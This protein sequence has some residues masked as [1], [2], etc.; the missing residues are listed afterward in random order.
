MATRPKRRKK[1]DSSPAVPA[2]SAPAT[3]NQSIEDL[4]RGY[5]SSI[6]PTI[7][8]TCRQVITEKMYTMQ[9]SA[10]SN[11]PPSAP[12]SQAPQQMA[13]TLTTPTLLQEITTE[14]AR[15]FPEISAHGQ[16]TD[17]GSTLL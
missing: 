13:P 6:I 9:T 12:P 17:T 2:T 15:V 4:V 11:T 7:K 14:G 8:S 1:G 10:A 3:T 16:R 5:M